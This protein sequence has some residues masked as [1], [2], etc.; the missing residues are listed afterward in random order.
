MQLETLT[1]PIV[2][3]V[4]LSEA[5]DHLNI[6]AS[7]SP[8]THPDDTKIERL[9]KSARTWV[10]QYMGRQLVRRKMRLTVPSLPS[11]Q[12]YVSPRGMTAMDI[13]FGAGVPNCVR[14]PGGPVYD[15]DQ[16]TYY[17][18]NNALQT[19]SSAT[20]RVINNNPAY[21]EQADGADWPSTANRSD[22]V[23]IDFWAGYQYGGGSPATGYTDNI[24]ETARDAI[25]MHIQMHY[26][27]L[28][29]KDREGVMAEIK[30]LLDPLRIH[31]FTGPFG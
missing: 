5:R 26:D 16:I 28:A 8:A 10:E 2:E 25:L 11:G 1:Q 14:L 19:L 20:Y 30:T 18:S 24:P 9:I 3:P 17:D 6:T 13:E 15:I 22:A 7:G 21:V 27:A 31:R 29:P 12:R 23:R 4:S